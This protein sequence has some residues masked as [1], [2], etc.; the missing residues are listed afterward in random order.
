VWASSARALGY[1]RSRT[2]SPNRGH[3]VVLWAFEREVVLG[4]HASA[5]ET[6]CTE[7]RVSS[8]SALS[9]HRGLDEAVR[10]AELVLSPSPRSM[11]APTCAAAA[12]ASCPRP[13]SSFALRDRAP[14][15]ATSTASLPR[16]A[17]RPCTTASAVLRDPP[18]P[19]RSRGACRTQR[20]RPPARTLHRPARPGCGLDPVLSRL[21]DR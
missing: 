4:I 2:S 11:F 12:R 6:P 1:G 13:R 17:G 8:R 18:L 9:V 20:H 19:S 7:Q 5:P 14:K 10:D 3:E 15:L 16:A 21:H